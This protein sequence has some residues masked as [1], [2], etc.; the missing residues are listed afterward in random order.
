MFDV[1]IGQKILPIIYINPQNFVAFHLRTQDE[2]F[3]PNYFHL[4]SIGKKLFEI[5]LA[6]TAL[7]QYFIDL[8]SN[9]KNIPEFK[10]S[11]SFELFSK[12]ENKWKSILKIDA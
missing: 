7:E 10:N 9:L 12:I 6:N 2:K 11:Y 3:Q 5:A 1:T 4:T 8:V